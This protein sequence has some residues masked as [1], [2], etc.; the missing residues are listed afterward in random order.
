MEL[1]IQYGRGKSPES[2]LRDIDTL[3]TNGEGN[4]EGCGS[5]LLTLPLKSDSSGEG[6]DG[7]RVD[8]VPLRL[9]LRIRWYRFQPSLAEDMERADVILCHAGAGT[10]LEALAISASPK[11]ASSSRKVVNAVI[12]SKLMDNHQSELAEELERRKHICVTK[13]CTLEWT[14]EEGA[15]AFWNGIAD[16]SPVPFIGG[17]SRSVDDQLERP[18]STHHVSNF[19][20]IVDRVMGFTE[21]RGS[22]DCN[23]K[24]I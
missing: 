11:S 16:F 5:A 24:T 17:L 4:D 22:E 20:R 23:K 1:I 9:R 10:L 14:T 21:M 6:I 15:E 19:Q 8:N 12:N 3:Q 13:D 18:G 7:R 2:F